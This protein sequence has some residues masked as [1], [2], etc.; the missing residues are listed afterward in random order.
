MRTHITITIGAVVLCLLLSGCGEGSQD[1]RSTHRMAGCAECVN[2]TVYVMG[3]MTLRKTLADVGA[4]DPAT[5][6]WNSR[7]AIPTSRLLAASAV[8]GK[9]LYVIGG[10]NE[11]GVLSTVERYITTEDKW[12]RCALMPTARWSLMASESGDRIYAFGG[13]SGTGNSRRA[14]DVV[15]VYDPNTDS[16]QT[17]GRMPEPRQ[18]AAVAA[19]NG[20]IYIISGKIASYV[21]TPASDQIITE[22]VDCFDPKTKTWTRAQDIPTG[23]VGAKAVVYKGEIYVVGGI[24]KG[25]GF[26]VQVDVFDPR[27][28]QWSDGPRLSSGRSAHMC[29]LAGDLII[30][31][32]GSSVRYGSGRQSIS[33]RMETVSISEYQQQ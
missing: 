15:E 27:S 26:P 12:A 21:E 31:F 19:V 14:L 5:K 33:D 7:R 23:R 8:H 17:I 30:V 13:I 11:R 3:G 25:G 1:R 9:D 10:R 20:L 16:W 6:I 29:A 28:N 18:G 24:A 4:Y 32:G 22:D 2:D